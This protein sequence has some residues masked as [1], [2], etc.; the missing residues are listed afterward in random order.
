MTKINLIKSETWSKPN[1]DEQY[2]ILNQAI[3]DYIEDDEYIINIQCVEENN[4]GLQ[5]FYIYTT[6]IIISF[7]SI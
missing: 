7:Q 2:D 3:Q 6:K 4:N 1:I 5:R